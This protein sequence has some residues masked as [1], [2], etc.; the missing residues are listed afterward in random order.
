[1]TRFCLGSSPKRAIR[2]TGLPP[3]FCRGTDATATIEGRT[4]PSPSLSDYHQAC[5][6]GVALKAQ[7]PLAERNQMVP[8]LPEG[9]F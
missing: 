6:P 8:A 7:S 9:L 3:Y 1:M 5:Q 2:K 4:L